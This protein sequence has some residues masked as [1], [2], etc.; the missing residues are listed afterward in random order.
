MKVLLTGGTGFIGSPV[1][2][3]LKQRDID[4]YIAVYH[5]DPALEMLKKEYHV[6][7]VDLLDASSRKNMLEIVNPDTLIHLAWYAEPN[8][9]WHSPV[10]YDWMFA[11]ADL[12]KHFVEQG[13]KRC[14]ITGT[15]AEYDWRQGGCLHEEKTPLHPATFYGVSKDALRRLCQ[16]LAALSETSFLWCRLF[17][18]FGPGEPAGR[19]FTSLEE[20]WRAGEVAICNAGNLK[21]DYMHVDDIAEALIA[22]SFSQLEGEINIASGQ[23]VALGDLAQH[24]AQ[25]RG[26][27]DLLEIR[28][29]E[30]SPNTPAELYADV[31]RLGTI[32]N[33]NG[34][35][36]P[37]DRILINGN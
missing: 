18:P 19:L 37:V 17:W 27:Q 34:L 16:G 26:M 2:R 14:M 13:G 23:S 36:P 12:Y 32:F 1:R 15:C 11:G 22:A 31:S 7:P 10:N 3:L 20:K 21:R 29:I 24:R 9:F 5:H 28:Q 25:Q 6:I 8:R 4:L 30:T 35:T 33:V